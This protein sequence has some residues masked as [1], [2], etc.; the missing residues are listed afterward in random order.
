MAMLIQENWRLN[1]P[2]KHKHMLLSGTAI[3]DFYANYGASIF[4]FFSLL[5]N[6]LNAL[7]YKILIREMQ[8]LQ[9]CIKFFKYKY[10]V[11]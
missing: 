10:F 9:F 5:I 8:M 7:I 2:R 4:K 11:K 3:I 1:R 6:R